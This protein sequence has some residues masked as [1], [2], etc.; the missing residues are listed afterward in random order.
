MLELLGIVLLLNAAVS[1]RGTVIAFKRAAAA[2]APESR[3]KG[4]S[5]YDLSACL[6]MG[7]SF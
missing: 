1:A 2:A 4:N 3:D 5:V 6:G 7:L